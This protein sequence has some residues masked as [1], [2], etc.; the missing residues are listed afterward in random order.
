MCNVSLFNFPLNILY[1]EI[2]SDT[3]FAWALNSSKMKTLFPDRTS[4]LR[5]QIEDNV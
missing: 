4:Q 5:N 3:L 2:N 1:T